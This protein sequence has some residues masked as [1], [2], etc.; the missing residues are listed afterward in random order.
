[1]EAAEAEAIALQIQR[2][3]NEEA[4]NLRRD[5]RM[6]VSVYVFYGFCLVGFSACLI[7]LLALY[8]NDWGRSCDVGMKVWSVVWLARMILQLICNTAV[9]AW[10]MRAGTSVPRAMMLLPRLVHAFGFTWW[11]LGVEQL[12]FEPSCEE[13]TLARTVSQVMFWMTGTVYLIPFVVYTLICVC[14]PCI[15]YFMVRFAVRPA[16]RQPTPPSL[17]QQ[18]E[19]KTYGDLIETLRR[20]YTLDTHEVDIQHERRTLPSLSLETVIDGVS[21]LLT[22]GPAAAGAPAPSTTVGGLPRTP[23]GAPW[24]IDLGGDSGVSASGLLSRQSI[25]VNKA[26]PICMV[27]LDD[28]DE[29][30]IMPCDSRHFFHRACV[31]HWLETSQACPICRANIVNILTGTP[32]DPT[33]L[34]VDHRDLEL[35]I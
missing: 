14:L 3:L 6:A 33:L 13:P 24:A 1:M 4:E 7:A 34:P 21:N 10:R 29:V 16:D 17:V 23:A 26:C 15:I 25:S 11:L 27:D 19:V 30:L 35:Q 18:L 9:T 28:E 5:R 32:S 20:Q 8:N 22:P 31:E 2:D 12:F